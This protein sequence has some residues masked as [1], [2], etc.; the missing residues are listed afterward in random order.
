MLEQPKRR[1]SISTGGDSRPALRI[2]GDSDL[3][4]LLNIT[5]T[6][7]EKQDD[8]KQLPESLT[9]GADSE[10]EDGPSTSGP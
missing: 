4:W 9:I 7:G 6:I 5:Q 2:V 8:I 10:N 1:L 3:E